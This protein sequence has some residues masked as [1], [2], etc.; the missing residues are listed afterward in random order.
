MIDVY[1]DMDG[2]V[3]NFQKCYRYPEWNTEYV[4]DF[5]E[6]DGFSKME[7]FPIAVDL[8][9]H[10]ASIQDVNVRFLSSLG[11]QKTLEKEIYRQK[12]EFLKSQGL[13]FELLTVFHKGM[14]SH[15]AT[16]YSVL[17]DDHPRNVQE[18]RMNNGNAIEIDSCVGFS[19]KEF[20]KLK[21]VISMLKDKRSTG[22]YSGN[23]FETLRGDL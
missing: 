3:C 22:I 14:K 16:P 2:V 11:A 5:L 6:R 13:N 1:F 21:K 23:T 19:G 8:V 18:F 9:K 12:R 20:L 4:E 7:P 10:I 15:F 17:L